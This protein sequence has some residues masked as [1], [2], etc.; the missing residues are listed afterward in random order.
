[1]GHVTLL[2]TDLSRIDSQST[3]GGINILKPSQQFCFMLLYADYFLPVPW[4]RDGTQ[5]QANVSLHNGGTPSPTT[6][7]LFLKGHKLFGKMRA[8]HL[9]EERVYTV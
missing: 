8:Q 7:S 9:M 3:R 5:G 2:C 1:M 4:G 6:P